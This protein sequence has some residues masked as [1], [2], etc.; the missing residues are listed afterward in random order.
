MY[1]RIWVFIILMGLFLLEGNRVF[2]QSRKGFDLRKLYDIAIEKYLS[3]SEVDSLSV[4][5]IEKPSFEPECSI[6][7]IEF[8][9]SIQLKANF[10]NE[11][12]F[13]QLWEHLQKYKDAEFEPEVGHYSV[14]V[15][16]TFNEKM[17]FL[18][19]QTM[20][21]KLSDPS[22]G[23]E[24][25]IDG[26]VYLFRLTNGKDLSWEVWEPKANS[27]PFKTASICK[28]IAIRLKNNHF[29]EMKIMEAIDLLDY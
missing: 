23:D 25:A 13:G 2:S 17:K 10:F 3:S 20:K 21:S 6:R 29:D 11:N 24:L 15:S 18:F 8:K 27:L 26:T 12:Y 5:Y 19:S 16:K 4:L 1:S 14:L 7:V 9:D 22:S 28:E